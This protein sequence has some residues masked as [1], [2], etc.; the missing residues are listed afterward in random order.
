MKQLFVPDLNMALGLI[1]G[2][3]VIPFVLARL[4]RK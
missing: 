4:N 2:V 3:F 1:V